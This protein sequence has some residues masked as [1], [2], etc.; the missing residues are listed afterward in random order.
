MNNTILK[1]RLAALLVS[2]TLMAGC[3]A[4]TP[5]LD[6]KFG[7]AVNTAKAQQIIHPD[8]SKNTNPV[9]G[10]DGQAANASIDRYHKSYE[11]PP[12]QPNVFTIGVGTGTSTSTGTGTTP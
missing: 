1:F 6:E 4:P 11:R 2:T 8:A 10:I 12:A 5:Y 3:A 9:A 7:E